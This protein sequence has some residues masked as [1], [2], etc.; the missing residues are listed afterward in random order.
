MH[1]RR[2]QENWNH[3]YTA[4]KDWIIQRSTFEFPKHFSNCIWYILLNEAQTVISLNVLPLSIPLCHL[5]CDALNWSQAELPTFQ[6]LQF[7]KAFT[8]IYAEIKSMFVLSFYK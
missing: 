2:C 1:L 8:G 4:K 6:K 3:V 7:P 5:F